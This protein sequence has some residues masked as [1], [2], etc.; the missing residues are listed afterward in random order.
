MESRKKANKNQSPDKQIVPI[1]VDCLKKV[2]AATTTTV[3]DNGTIICAAQFYILR[4][5]KNWTL[6]FCFPC[7]TFDVDM[8][9]SERLNLPPRTATSNRWQRPRRMVSGV[10]YTYLPTYLPTAATTIITSLRVGFPV[11]RS[12]FNPQMANKDVS[13]EWNSVWSGDWRI[14]ADRTGSKQFAKRIDV[15]IADKRSNAM[16]WKIGDW[17]DW[18]VMGM[19]D[20][21]RNKNRGNFNR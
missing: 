4:D 21:W 3:P 10:S 2:T 6:Y 11:E 1:R 9:I 17:R 19:W 16:N 20:D 8:D 12:T 7:G 14:H 5:H 13:A 15:S 18:S